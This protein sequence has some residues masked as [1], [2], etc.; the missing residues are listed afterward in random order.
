M[1]YRIPV[2]WSEVLVVEVEA[3]SIDEAIEKVENDEVD[4]DL[5]QGD[6]ADD[7]FIVL[8]DAARD[9]ARQDAAK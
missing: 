6:Y 3:D 1:K 8:E 9:W 2:T 5:S 4:I 7:S